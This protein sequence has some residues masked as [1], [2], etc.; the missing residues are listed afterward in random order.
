MLKTAFKLVGMDVLIHY[1]SLFLLLIKKTE[2]GIQVTW[3]PHQL[4]YYNTNQY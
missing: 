2:K 4:S 1:L 3:Y